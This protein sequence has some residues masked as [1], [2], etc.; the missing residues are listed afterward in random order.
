M[1]WLIDDSTFQRME[2]AAQAGQVP[3]ATEQRQYEDQ[4]QA[5]AVDLP[6]GMSVAGDRAAIRIQ[7]ALTDAPDLFARWFG[8]GNTVYGDISNAIAVADADPS[9]QSIDIDIDSPGGQAS[10]EWFRAMEAVANAAKPTRAVVRGMAASAAYGLASQADEIVA[11]NPMASVGS[12]GV[13]ARFFVSDQTV[14]VTSTNAP[15]KRPD[16]TSEAGRDTIRALLDQI[17]GQFIQA[18]GRGRKKDE[19]KVRSDFGRGAMF[20][21]QQAVDRGMIDGIATDTL[22][23]ETAEAIA[24]DTPL[25][26]VQKMDLQTLKA[27]HPAV[28]A[29]ATQAGATQERSRVAAHLDLGASSGAMDIAQEA[30]TSG[31]ECDTN[32]QSKYLSAKMRS[33]DASA[34]DGDEALVAG[35]LTNVAG[36]NTNTQLSAEETR[37]GQVAAALEELLGMEGQDN[38]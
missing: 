23:T 25:A 18:I 19:D 34:Q 10:A 14:E 13:V 5:E 38:A 15:N 1:K 12:I 24:G 28:Y 33:M 17:E 21:A 36:A 29:E 32:M 11:V 4:L 3:T 2:V 20:L 30:I 9:I 16:P 6:R 22:N 26:G 35:A 37:G 31:A 7:G 27:E 8:G